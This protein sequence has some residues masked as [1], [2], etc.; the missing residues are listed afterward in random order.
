[1]QTSI[2]FPPHPREIINAITT[3]ATATRSQYAPLLLSIT[4]HS[5]VSSNPTPI[6]VLSMITN[7]LT[8]HSPPLSPQAIYL[9][10]IP[11]T[12]KP[13]IQINLTTFVDLLKELP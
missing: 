13:L 11:S 4:I 5:P 12:T 6:S 8:T 9:N 10:H 7:L 1:M 2:P 3:L